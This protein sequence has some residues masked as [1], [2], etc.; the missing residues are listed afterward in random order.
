GSGRLQSH[1]NRAAPLATPPAALA[2]RHE[3]V[4]R[5]GRQGPA[6]ER[7]PPAPRLRTSPAPT[8]EVPSKAPLEAPEADCLAR[9]SRKPTRTIARPAPRVLA[10]PRSS[11]P[12]GRRRESAGARARALSARLRAPPPTPLVGPRSPA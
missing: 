6:R 12:R 3:A 2:F 9:G 5:R 4:R 11:S 7:L 8:R 10:E 1:L